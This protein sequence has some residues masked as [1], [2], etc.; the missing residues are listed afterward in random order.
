MEYW[1]LETEILKLKLSLL[2]EMAVQ[3]FPFTIATL[4]SSAVGDS[5]VFLS[6]SSLGLSIVKYNDVLFN[7]ASHQY[8]TLYY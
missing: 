8:T 2:S 5:E 4:K 3:Y 1:S 6:L 7:V